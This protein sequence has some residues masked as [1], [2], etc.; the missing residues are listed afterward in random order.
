MKELFSISLLFLLAILTGQIKHDTLQPD[1]SQDTII[2]RDNTLPVSKGSIQADEKPQ[3]INIG[4]VVKMSGHWF[5]AYR[6]GYAQTQADEITNSNHVSS[7]FLKR[8]YF[9]LEKDLNETFSVRYTQDI[10]VDTEGDDAGNVETRLKYLYV[11]AKPKLNIGWMTDLWM[12][13]GMVHRPWLDYE[14]KINTYRAQDNMAIERNKIFNSADF[15]FTIGGN[16]GPKMDS[17]DKHL[18]GAMKGKYLS[19]VFGIYNGGGYSGA[20]K[21]TNKVIAGRV[22]VRPFAERFPELQLSGYFNLGKGNSPYNPDFKQYLGFLAYTG[23][24]LTLTGQYHTG[25]GDFRA[26]YVEENDPSKALENH[27]YSFFGE[28]KIGETPWAIWGRHDAFTVEN[29]NNDEISRYIGGISYKYNKNI[30][31]ILDTEHTTQGDETDDVYELT[32]E[33]IF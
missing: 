16:I 1:A 22:S 14:Q 25:V 30:R 15:G 26:K 29:G 24:N 13:G 12:E 28:Y 6:D 5:I 20:E 2:V 17:K 32:L 31:L 9:T 19:Y 33:V 3:Y 18:N 7:V 23:K 27:G 8:S 10:T 11:R 21:N 4:D